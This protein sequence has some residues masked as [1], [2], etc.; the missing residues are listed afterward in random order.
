LE[1]EAPHIEKARR[2]EFCRLTQIAG[3]EDALALAREIMTNE[4]SRAAIEQIAK[5]YSTIA[6]LGLENNFDVD[7]GDAKGLEY[8]TGLTFKVYVPGWSVEIGSGGRYDNL[9]GNFGFSEPA[10]GFS[11]ALDGLAGAVS[12]RSSQTSWSSAETPQ[13]VEYDGDPDKLVET[14]EAA[15][16]HRAQEER[17]EI[18]F[19]PKK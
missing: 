8:Y 7:L 5:I 10:V 19:G 3:K 12:H 13:S 15:C 1:K 17:V 9:I 4:R 16:R 18:K 2:V 6:R 11:F 14:F